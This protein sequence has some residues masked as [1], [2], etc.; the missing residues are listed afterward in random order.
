MPIKSP[1]TASEK[2]AVSQ[3]IYTSQNMD[4]SAISQKYPYFN[5]NNPNETNPNNMNMNNKVS[6][7]NTDNSIN[8]T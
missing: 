7:K 8:S 2:A 3:F 4:G 6:R 5:N 1:P